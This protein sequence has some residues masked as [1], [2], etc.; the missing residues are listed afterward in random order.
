M[1]FPSM[2]LSNSLKKNSH[3]D[4]AELNTKTFYKYEGHPEHKGHLTW[5]EKNKL[6]G[7]KPKT[8]IQSLCF[9]ASL[10]KA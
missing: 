6:S 9:S 2:Y 4:I 5:L 8:N 7:K 1:G 3:Y 10:T